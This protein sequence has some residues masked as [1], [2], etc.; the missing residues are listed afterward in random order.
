[1]AG[2]MRSK[3]NMPAAVLG[4]VVGIG[5]LGFRHHGLLA[6]LPQLVGRFGLDRQRF[7]WSRA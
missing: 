7:C 1:M 4:I 6:G 2:A 5:M 3:P